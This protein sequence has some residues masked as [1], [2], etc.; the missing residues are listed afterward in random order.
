[1]P[2]ERSPA[3]FHG[4]FVDDRN[5]PLVLTHPDPRSWLGEPSGRY[6]RVEPPRLIPVGSHPVRGGCW[7][8]REKR[9]T[10]PCDHVVGERLERNTHKEAHGSCMTTHYLVSTSQREKA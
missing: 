10:L 3:M 6:P 2:V 1:M 8:R 4:T 9:G 7:G 5:R